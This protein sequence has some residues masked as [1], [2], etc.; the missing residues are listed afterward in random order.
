MF[1]STNSIMQIII[2]LFLLILL[3]IMGHTVLLFCMTGNF[4]LEVRHYEFYFLST[5][6]FP[7]HIMQFFSLN[8]VKLLGKV[9]SFSDLLLIFVCGT[10]ASYYLVLILL[11][12]WDPLLNAP[13][14]Y[15]FSF[16]LE[17]TQTIPGPV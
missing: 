1:S 15:S 12:W 16:F 9:W 4:L 7:I 2:N 13:W 6:Y 11:H 5:G 3:L 14:I 8:I 17:W 10:R